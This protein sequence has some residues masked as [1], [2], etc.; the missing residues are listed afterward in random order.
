MSSI[1]MWDG[2]APAWERHAAFVDGHTAAATEV[3]L[4]RAEVGPGDAVLDLACGAGGAGLAAVPLVGENGSVFLSDGSPQMVSIAARRAAGLPHVRAA[5]VDL[6]AIDLAYRSFDA[7][8]CRHGL[9]FL[10]DPPAVLR[11]TLQLLRLSGRFAAATWDRREANPWLGI[12]L[13]AV[14]AQFNM[15]FPPPGVRGPFSLDDP[16]VLAS[17]L[18][19]AG[20]A[21]VQV[22]T[23]STPMRAASLEDW[24]DRVPELAGPLAHALAGMEPEARD[25]IRDRAL[26]AAAERSRT[27]PDGIELDGSILVASGARTGSQG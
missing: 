4:A 14:G 5:V 2:V 9:M 13:D 22:E 25:A 3:M 15:R 17:L 8:L 11:S 19:E 21:E 20:F 26:A 12:V 23:V 10:E 7:V 1:E 27:T 6:A 18:G 24:W 16:D